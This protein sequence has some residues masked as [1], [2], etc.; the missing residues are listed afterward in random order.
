MFELFSLS[1]FR[2]TQALNREPARIDIDSEFTHQDATQVPTQAMFDHRAL[3][4]ADCVVESVVGL[5]VRLHHY[6][7][8]N[9]DPDS[10][11]QTSGN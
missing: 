5:A 1:I 11:Q 10:T 8:A 2:R 9:D 4:L 7:R 3:A 6:S